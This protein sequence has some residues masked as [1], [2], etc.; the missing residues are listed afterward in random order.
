MEIKS[1]IVNKLK[2]NI[3]Y[4]INNFELF[5]PEHQNGYIRF[6][7][8]ELHSIYLENI[9]DKYNNNIIL[10]FDKKYQFQAIY[11]CSDK[12]NEYRYN[13]DLEL[14][15]VYLKDISILPNISID[16]PPVYGPP[17]EMMG[18]AV[19]TTDKYR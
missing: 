18:P 8:N 6:D 1:N 5:Y 4:Y 17:V 9:I 14:D 13:K 16:K 2:D 11:V 15:A 3:P 10:K 12:C 7:N 19:D